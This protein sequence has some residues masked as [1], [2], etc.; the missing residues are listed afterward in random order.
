[1]ILIRQ[2]DVDGGSGRKTDG[3]IGCLIAVK[4]I[5]NFNI[6]TLKSLVKGLELFS[7][8]SKYSA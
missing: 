4:V 5:N 1:V 7:G 8:P 2:W 6:N 3:N